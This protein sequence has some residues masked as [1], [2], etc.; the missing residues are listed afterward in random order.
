MTRTSVA[1][2]LPVRRFEIWGCRVRR[3][4]DSIS[5]NAERHYKRAALWILAIGGVFLLIIWLLRGVS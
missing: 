2:M 5:P 1:S 4:G 3:T